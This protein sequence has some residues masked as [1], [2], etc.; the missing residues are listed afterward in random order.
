M[1]AAKKRKVEYS[2]TYKAGNDI[3]TPKNR[4]SFILHLQDPDTRIEGIEHGKYDDGKG[5]FTIKLDDIKPRRQGIGRLILEEM[6]QIHGYPEQLFHIATQLE[7]SAFIEFLEDFG[8]RERDDYKK[9]FPGAPVITGRNDPKWDSLK[10]YFFNK[11]KLGFVALCHY[12]QC[13]GF[14]FVKGEPVSWS[15]SGAISNIFYAYG[16]TIAELMKEMERIGGQLFEGQWKKEYQKKFV[17][18][19]KMAS[20]RK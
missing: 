10:E 13:S 6:E 19:K 14:R 15:S 12:N 17:D 9:I 8:D 11:N 5:F 18:S 16:E 20:K 1:A 3:G 2:E 4:E 7:A